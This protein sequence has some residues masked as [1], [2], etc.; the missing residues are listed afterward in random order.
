[1]VGR[2]AKLNE[3]GGSFVKMDMGVIVYLPFKQ[4]RKYWK[5]RKLCLQK[6]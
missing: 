1:M 6:K 4:Q 5:Q 2:W 3:N